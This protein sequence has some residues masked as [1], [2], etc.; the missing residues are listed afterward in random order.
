MKN[1]L[2]QRI[3][4][5]AEDAAPVVP[6][7]PDEVDE[8]VRG[9][10]AEYDQETGAVDV[11]AIPS[12]QV[13]QSLAQAWK[14]GQQTDVASQL[15]FTPVSYADFVKLCFVIGQGD[16]VQ[17]GLML[18][19]L[20]ESEGMVADE[21]S[22]NRILSRIGHQRDLDAGPPEQEAL[23]PEEEQMPEEGAV[24]PPPPPRR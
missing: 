13:V 6:P 5:L 21:P 2:I 3:C 11:E 9:A 22:E 24:Q 23:P 10:R 1:S 18:D 15:L 17:L 8:P 12:E 16:A 20:A 19:D 4:G 14:S 7:R